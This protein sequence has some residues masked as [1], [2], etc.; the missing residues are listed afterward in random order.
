MELRSQIAKQES[1]IANLKQRYREKHPKYI[2]A[3][4]QLAEWQNAFRKAV[5]EVPQ[6]IRS[7]FENARVA[8]T[9]LEQALKEQE[10][11]ALELSK[12]SIRYNVL[13]R[14]VETDRA[15]YQSV[16]SRIKETDITKEMKPSNVR[17]I[18]VAA[19][20]EKPVKP[21]KVRV[22]AL[23]VMAG[24]GLGVLLVFFL[25]SLDQSLKT[26]DQAEDYLQLPVLST[27]PK[28]SGLPENHRQLIVA[29]EAHSAEAESFRTLRTALSMLGR[30]EDRRVFLFTSALPSEGKTFCSLNYALSL[31]RQG[32]RTL[33]IDCDLRRPMVEK[34]IA[35]SNKRATG[36]TDF[37]TGQKRFE[38]IVH[39]TDHENLSYIPS[40]TEAPNPAELLAQTGIEGLLE[41]ALSRYD[42]VVI[43]SAPIHAVSDTLLIAS[44]VQ[45]VCLVVRAAKTPRNAILRAV[46]LLREAQAPLS[47]VLL[48]MMPR[49]KS[50]GYG[51]YYYD[52]YYDYAYR[53]D[54]YGSKDGRKTKRR[55]K[56]EP[57]QA[58]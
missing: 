10:T 33:V 51:Y 1:D 21:Q 37:L 53:G 25:N 4:S 9:A 34:S 56:E 43:D 7:T 42:R 57:A 13:L 40:G 24:L 15:M 3:H 41:E 30:K 8:E 44:R 46:Q 38:E 14:D 28:F 27:I 54:Y 2:Q 11:A 26:V 17:V 23:G 36:L 50:R 47:G 49:R 6:T 22:A 52:S 32:L 35:R 29:D 45:T 48:N 31:A 12:Q 5:L 55:P 19:L 58:A 18:Q 16:L 39:S 20:P